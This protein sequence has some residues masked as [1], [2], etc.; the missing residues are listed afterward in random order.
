MPYCNL[1][2]IG[3]AVYPMKRE[4]WWFDSLRFAGGVLKKKG[5]TE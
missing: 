3:M 5:T 4:F 2:H 1:D